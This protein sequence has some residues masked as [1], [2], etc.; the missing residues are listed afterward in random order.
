MWMYN[1]NRYWRGWFNVSFHSCNISATCHLEE[2]A[3]P[4]DSSQTQADV[5]LQWIGNRFLQ[6]VGQHLPIFIVSH[7]QQH[8]RGDTKLSISTCRS[9]SGLLR[10]HLGVLLLT[11]I[12]LAKI[13]PHPISEEVRC[14]YKVVIAFGVKLTPIVDELELIV[15]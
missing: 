3:L 6:Q 2:S 13:H 15:T 14:A 12:Y 4:L 10:T 5:Q 1:V 8:H 11:P 7:C 9:R